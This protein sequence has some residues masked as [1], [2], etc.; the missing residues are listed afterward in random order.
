MLRNI[1]SETIELASSIYGD[2]LFKPWIA[3]LNRPAR[4]PQIA[5][6]D[7]VMV[8]LSDFLER[9]ND[10]LTK[11]EAVAEATREMIMNEPAGTFTGQ[12]NTKKS[13]HTRIDTY[14]EML[15][16]ALR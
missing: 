14:K 10:L 7:A 5:F 2:S 3:K 12:G 11:A 1:F 8:G 4:A 6:A 9:R 13:I 16:T 15:A